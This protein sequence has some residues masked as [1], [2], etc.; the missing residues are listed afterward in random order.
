MLIRAIRGRLTIQSTPEQALDALD[1]MQPEQRRQAEYALDQ[2]LYR[3]REATD[4]A[5]LTEGLGRL[6]RGLGRNHQ[7]GG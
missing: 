1:R 4:V 5:M 7:E 3:D 2:L 6:L